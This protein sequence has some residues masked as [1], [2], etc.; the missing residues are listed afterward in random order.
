MCG[1]YSSDLLSAKP[2]F[3]LKFCKNVMAPKV[4][5]SDTAVVL[6]RADGKSCS[7]FN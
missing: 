5:D 3:D 4:S 6:K 7:H 1:S 2:G